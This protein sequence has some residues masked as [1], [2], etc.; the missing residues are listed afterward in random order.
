MNQQ[1]LFIRKII[2]FS[3]IALLLFPLFLLSQPATT[4]SEGGLLARLRSDA[5]LTQANLGQIDPTSAS[6]KLATFGLHGAATTKLWSNAIKYK[7]REDFTNFGA[8]LQQITYLQPHFVKVWEFQGHNV[9]F[10]ISVEFDDYRDRYHYVRKGFNLLKEGIR[11]NEKEPK[12]LRVLAHFTGFKIGR[13]DEKKFY[14]VMYREDDDYHAPPRDQNPLWG[15]RYQRPEALRDSWLVSKW[16]YREAEKLILNRL[17]SYG[18]MSPFLLHS[19]PPRQQMQYAEAIEKEGEF[20]TKA[21][22]AWELADKEWQDF[23]ARDLPTTLGF[24]I[25][26]SQQEHFRKL[27]DQYSQELNELEAGLR[28]TMKQKVL[29]SLASEE[30][31]ARNTPPEERNPDEAKIAAD[32]EDRL[33]IS[34][35]QLVE[36]LPEEKRQKALQLKERYDYAN[37]RFRMIEKYRE[38]VNYAYWERRSQIEQSTDT[39]AARQN[40]YLGKK[41]YRD[42][43]LPA[44]RQHFEQGIR[45]WSAVLTKYPVLLDEYAMV[46]DLMKMIEGYQEILAQTRE[47]GSRQLPDDFDLQNVVDKWEEYQG[48]K[49]GSGSTNK[50]T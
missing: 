34:F 17:A 48:P 4:F 44:A 25:R 1:R 43:D 45:L 35:D 21:K 12:L 10:N 2:Y 29:D 28:D 27:R 42:G 30:L 3:A 46:D 40:I 47:D 38:V 6:M 18:T 41:A 23:G 50:A 20:G 13:S 33:N 7:E 5:G 11:Y 32:V 39:I 14:R 15:T 22:Q 36:E 49:A 16:W 37:D 26:L 8:T 24:S 19:D 31:A 9:A